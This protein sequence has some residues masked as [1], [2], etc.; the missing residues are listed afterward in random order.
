MVSTKW[1]IIGVAIIVLA[2]LFAISLTINANII[3]EA[4][5]GKYTITK[6]TYY[7][8]EPQEV[9]EEVKNDTQNISGPE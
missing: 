7:R 2:V 4:P 1:K 8:I 3:K 9:N 6:N 5:E